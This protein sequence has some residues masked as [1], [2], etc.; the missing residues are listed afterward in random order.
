M[1]VSLEGMT[2]EQIAEMAMLTKTMSDNP[3]TRGRFLGMMK[4]LDPNTSIPEVDIARGIFG[5]LKPALDKIEKL[6]NEAQVRRAEAE[7]MS[8]RNSLY[9][10]GFTKAEVESAEK[11][12]ID[13]GIS[14]HA[15]A[16]RLLR[17]E[18]QAAIPTPSSFSQPAMP[19]INVKEMGG[20]INSWARNEATAALTDIMKARRI[21]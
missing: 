16:A 4:E 14:D 8:R 21:A 9:E 18:Q 3:K 12:M 15:T 20:N 13:K 5:A 7:V 2:P 6:D 10:S 19:K 11:L 17:L 1:A